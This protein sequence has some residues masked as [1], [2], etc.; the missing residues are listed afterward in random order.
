[1]DVIELRNLHALGLAEI[2]QLLKRAVENGPFLAPAGWDTVATDVFQFVTDPRQFMLLGAE[3]GKFR[4]VVLGFFPTGNLFPYPTVVLFYNEGSRALSRL[5][6]ERLLDTIL[7]AGYTKM[8]AINGT[9]EPDPVW[10]RALTPTG[11]S[12]KKAGSLMF[13]EVK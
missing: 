6:Q 5:T 11:V 10:Q 4:S 13:F 8:I 9:G 1:M 3:N 2:Q 7:A 12:S